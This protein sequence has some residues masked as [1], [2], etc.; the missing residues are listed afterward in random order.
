MNLT[1]FLL[2]WNYFKILKNLQNWTSQAVGGPLQFLMVISGHSAPHVWCYSFTKVCVTLSSSSHI[3]YPPNMYFTISR[4]CLFLE[5]SFSSFKIFIGG[6]FFFVIY[7]FQRDCIT[8]SYFLFFLILL[9]GK[10]DYFPVSHLCSPS[11][12]ECHRCYKSW[13]SFIFLSPA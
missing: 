12:C 13:V 7:P 9:H 2:V 1:T 6:N 4:L 8:P 3:P 10:H 5:N 11:D